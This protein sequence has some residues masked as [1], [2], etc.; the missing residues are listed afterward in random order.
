M[1]VPKDSTNGPTK[2]VHGSDQQVI[3]R[4]FYTILIPLSIQEFEHHAPGFREGV[5]QVVD[6]GQMFRERNS[7]LKFH[8]QSLYLQRP[9]HK[10][11]LKLGRILG[12][13][14]EGSMCICKLRQG[15]NPPAVQAEVEANKTLAILTIKCVP[16]QYI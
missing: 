7:I 6:G 11:E 8:P 4:Q 9:E 12:Q 10:T 5:E 16:T 13:H 15:V 3:L 1:K 14:L 2:E